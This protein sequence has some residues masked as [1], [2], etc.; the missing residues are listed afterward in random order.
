MA[1]LVR[2]TRAPRGR[3]PLI[4]QKAGSREK[5]SVIAALSLAPRRVR[6]GLYF[7]TR[8]EGYFD[9]DA[10]AG[11][12]RELLTH[13]RGQVV[14]IR[15]DGRMH[16]GEPIR[17]AVSA[18]PRLSPER[19]PPYTP[20]SNPVGWPWSFLEYGEMANFAPRDAAH[21]D[22]VMTD[23]LTPIRQQPG[24]IRGFY[25]GAKIP[26]LDR[27][28]PTRGSTP[29]EPLPVLAGGCQL[30]GDGGGGD[31]FMATG[32]PVSEGH[33]T[34]VFRAISSW[35]NLRLNFLGTV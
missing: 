28:R 12:L 18:F 13:L 24:R 27:G 32:L 34:G 11:F 35:Q 19:L 23:H 29:A 14:V 20:E 9:S 31:D 21:L 30:R 16:E 10:V 4:Q 2:R 7:R 1:P 3:T 26:L 8:P 25:A 33:P 6:L 17:K 5:V 15:D 22:G